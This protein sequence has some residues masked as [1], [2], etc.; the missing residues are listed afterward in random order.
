[1][2]KYLDGYKIIEEYTKGNE[3][4]ILGYAKKYIEYRVCHLCDGVVMFGNYFLDE[5][6]AENDFLERVYSL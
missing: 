3:R 5:D 1:M 4:I 2:A 6:D